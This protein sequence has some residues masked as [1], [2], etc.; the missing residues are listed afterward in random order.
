M[1]NNVIGFALAALLLGGLFYAASHRARHMAAPNPQAIA[2]AAKSI[3]SGFVG[4]RRV[5]AWIVNCAAKPIVLEPKA[6][7]VKTPAAN[8]DTAHAPAA[9]AQKA[10]APP[11]TA[12][13]ADQPAAKAVS[14]GRCRTFVQFRAQ[15]A[16]H[17]VRLIIAFRLVG[18]D[19]G[20]LGLIVRMARGKKGDSVGL[21][22]GQAALHLSVASCSKGGCTSFGL[23]S[24]AQEA[25]FHGLTNGELVLPPAANGKRAA[26]LVPLTGLVGA[27]AAMRRAEA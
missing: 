19:A 6:A 24:P 20:K 18:P 13:S 26:V 14:L 27:L 17:K 8:T 3:Q 5:G 10:A 4:S 1:R 16:P 12:K 22:L 23:L 2:A 7:T 21:R 25:R 9:A 15:R 11:E